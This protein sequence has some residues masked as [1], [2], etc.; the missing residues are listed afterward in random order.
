MFSI[1]KKDKEEPED[2]FKVEH[3][4]DAYQIKEVREHESSAK[5]KIVDLET[6]EEIED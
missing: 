4:E 3:K 5:F 1:F 6:G 2:G